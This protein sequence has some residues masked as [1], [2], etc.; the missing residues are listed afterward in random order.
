M[1][2]LCLVAILVVA[3]GVIVSTHKNNELA[4]I[5][6]NGQSENC[7]SFISIEFH[8]DEFINILNIPIT[9]SVEISENF[10][11]RIQVSY[12]GIYFIQII[13]QGNFRIN[14]DVYEEGITFIFPS[15]SVR[16][17]TFSRTRNTITIGQSHLVAL[18]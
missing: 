8:G 17:N 5:F 13:Q 7:S 14:S 12:D 10:S 18:R 15:G 1:R 3:V 2:L 9:P 16:H 4:G 11:D 6:T